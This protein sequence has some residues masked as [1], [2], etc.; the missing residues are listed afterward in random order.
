MTNITST[1]SSTQRT[2]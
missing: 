1:S 2:V